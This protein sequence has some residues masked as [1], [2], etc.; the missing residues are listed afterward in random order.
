[1]RLGLW[2]GCGERWASTV[3][4]G[5]VIGGFRVGE[6]LARGAMGAVYLAEDDGRPA[7]RAEAA[8][9]RARPRRAVP[10]ALPAGVA[11][12]GDARPPA[13]RARR[14]RPAR[15]AA[16]STSRWPTS[17]AS[18]CA[19][20]CD[21]RAGSSPARAVGLVQQVG[22]A[23]DAAHA[24]GLVHRDVKPGNVLV[25]DGPDGEQAYVCD[26]GLARHVSSVGSLTG[27]RGFVGTVDYVA[28]EQIRGETVDGRADVYALGCVLFECLAGERPFE[29]ESELAVVFAHL[30][31]PPPRLT[32][33]RPELPAAW[34][35]V[36]ARA[37]AKEPDERYA[38]LRRARRRRG[39]RAARARGAARAPSRRARGRG[40]AARGSRGRRGRRRA[41]A[42]R[43]LAA[44]AEAGRTATARA[45]RG[46]RDDR[47]ER[48]RASARA[49]GS[50]TATHRPTS[51]SRAA[52]RGSC[53]R[54]SSGCCA[55]TRARTQLTG[56]VRL[57]WVPLGRLAAAGGF[58][59]AAQDG[60][61]ELARIS[62]AT[63][64]LDRLPPGG[65]AVDRAHGRRRLAVGRGRGR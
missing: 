9:A 51:S 33:A 40:V 6:L 45:R 55:S 31:E 56:R 50:A 25:A 14:S 28:P 13:R 15:T 1:M 46:R 20:S 19:S 23:L 37:L 30:N 38:T 2:E 27:D 49:R 63:G 52:R 5:S 8:L 57:P 26:F 42:S 21:A 4:P 54:A 43:R 64:R 24:A 18:T 47:V 48:S 16:C 41:R 22:E 11:A 35:G 17:T 36:V 3:P 10:A 53:S 61:P 32:A 7:R 12:R 29:R 59:W 58:V 34:D 62:T 39:R 60:G 65:L 44:V